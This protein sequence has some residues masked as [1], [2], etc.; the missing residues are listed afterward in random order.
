MQNSEFRIQNS[1]CSIVAQLADARVKLAPVA[2]E[3]AG[4]EARVLAAHAWGMSAEALV[5]HANAP[6]NAAAFAALVERRLQAEPVAQI[7]GEKQFW[8][9]VFQVSAEVLTPRADSETMIECLLRH[10]PQKDAALRMLDLGTG[11][12]CLLLS[13]LREYGNARGVAVDQSDAALAVAAGNA[14]ALGLADRCSMLRSNWCSNLA[15]TFDVVLANPPYIPT[16]DIAGLAAD[17]RG[18]EPHGALDG[19]A[20]GL[21]CYR[22]I[23]GTLEASRGALA[24]HLNAGALVLF[25]VGMGQADDVAAL[26]QAAGFS[27][28]EIANDLAGIARVVVFAMNEKE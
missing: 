18:F 5:L 17:V 3:N 15:G 4:L 24:G 8:R 23:L 25:E 20:D 14:A 22:R 6:Q 1:D 7:I 13:A 9:D 19:G 2:H 28:K 10:R 27:V 16:D 12:G 11:T 21:D 26:G